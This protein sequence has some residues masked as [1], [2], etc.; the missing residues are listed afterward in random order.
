MAKLVRNLSEFGMR[1]E[2]DGGNE[3]KTMSDGHCIAIFKLK[4]STIEC[5]ATAMDQW[6][7]KFHQ[8]ARAMCL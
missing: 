5:A 3:I 1:M 8:D 6:E 7:E 2:W 4:S